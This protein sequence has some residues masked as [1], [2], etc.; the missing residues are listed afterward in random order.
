MNMETLD[1][2]DTGMI[3]AQGRASGANKLL[4]L[5]VVIAILLSSVAL[6]VALIS[7][8]QNGDTSTVIVTGQDGSNAEDGRIW[9]IAMGHYQSNYIYIDPISGQLRGFLVDMV[10]AV[11]RMGNK[12]CNLVYDVWQHC[13]DSEKGQVQR[14]GV[15]LMSGW[16]DACAG[17]IKSHSRARTF[18][19][20][21]TWSKPVDY[22]FIIKTGN[23]RGFNPTDVTNMTFG[24]IDGFINDE[25]CLARQTSIKGST[26]SVT[27]IH[28]YPLPDD[29]LNAVLSG[30]VDAC[31]A[32]S[33]I[34]LKPGLQRLDD[35]VLDCSMDASGAAIMMRMDNPLVEWWDPALERLIQTSEYWEICQDV[36]DEHGHMPGRDP[37]EMCIGY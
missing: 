10:N 8:T 32:Y 1:A 26:L 3:L 22:H 31:I 5:M 2:S 30:E 15:G 21:K 24:F 13:W 37:K 9:N 23:P 7:L 27:Q 6:V 20:S 35:P 14:G 36:K 4:M 19:F 16:Y 25:F 18:K 28:H 12:N 29:M 17:W 11:C 34:D 33:H